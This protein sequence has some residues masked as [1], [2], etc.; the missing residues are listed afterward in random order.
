[1]RKCFNVFL[2][3]V[4]S[5]VVSFQDNDCRIFA[6]F[7]MNSRRYEWLNSKLNYAKY[8]ATTMGENKRNEIK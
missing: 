1:M 5:A 8:L 2:D 7:K 3:S 6:L 4:F